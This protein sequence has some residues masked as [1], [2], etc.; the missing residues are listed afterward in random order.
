MK[1]NEAAANCFTGLIPP[2][3]SLIMMEDWR[4]REWNYPKTRLR[5]NCQRRGTNLLF[6]N[7]ISAKLLQNFWLL[8]SHS[9]VLRR[10]KVVSCHKVRFL[11]AT[12]VFRKNSLFTMKLLARGG[13]ATVIS[14]TSP[15][16]IIRQSPL[17][18][19]PRKLFIF[20]PSCWRSYHRKTLFGCLHIPRIEWN[21]NNKKQRE[22]ETWKNMPTF[23]FCGF[24]FSTPLEWVFSRFSFFLPFFNSSVRWRNEMKASGLEKGFKFLITSRR[25]HFP[26]NRLLEQSIPKPF[27]F[28]SRHYWPRYHQQNVL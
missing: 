16:L 27:H 28:T 25:I 14:H 9:L 4:E 3:D 12:L 20:A 17:F 15:P 5:L 6:L 23:V 8:C 18:I 21:S 26:I 13:L 1:T 2:F 24:S 11:L 7:F 19:S 22:N 10:E